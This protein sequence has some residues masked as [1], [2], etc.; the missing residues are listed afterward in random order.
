MIQKNV[1]PF[2]GAEF[3]RIMDSGRHHAVRGFRI[4]EQRSQAGEP[5]VGQRLE[6]D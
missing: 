3:F 2:L 1:P 5:A 4:K 6:Q